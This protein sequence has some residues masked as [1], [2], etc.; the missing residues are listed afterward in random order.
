MNDVHIFVNSSCCFYAC[1]VITFSVLNGHLLR[2]KVIVVLWQYCFHISN[3]FR[4]QFIFIFNMSGISIRCAVV[5]ER[6][7]GSAE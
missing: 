4:P 2:Y 1:I 5:T 3:Y 6:Y 7:L